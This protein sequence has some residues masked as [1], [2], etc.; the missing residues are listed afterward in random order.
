MINEALIK[1]GRIDTLCVR[2]NY[3]CLCIL[4]GICV[5]CSILIFID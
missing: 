1:A 5:N 4:C 3:V 2:T